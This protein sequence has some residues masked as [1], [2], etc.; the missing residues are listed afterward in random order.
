M[1]IMDRKEYPLGNI[2]ILNSLF[3]FSHS[4]GGTVSQTNNYVKNKTKQV[5]LVV[6]KDWKVLHRANPSCLV[7]Q[8]AL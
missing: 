4:V 3:I 6:K 1:N 8:E 7:S 2:L 5:A